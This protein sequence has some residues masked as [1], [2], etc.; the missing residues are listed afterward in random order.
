VPGSQGNPYIIRTSFFIRIVYVIFCNEIRGLCIVVQVFFCAL[1]DVA[2]Q[3]GK[4]DTAFAILHEM[5]R[6]GINPGPSTYNTLMVVCSN[7][8]R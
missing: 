4:L 3:A 6:K 7:V 1:I 5:K 2:G 8:S